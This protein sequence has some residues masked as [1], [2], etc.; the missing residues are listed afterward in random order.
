MEYVRI[1]NGVPQRFTDKDLKSFVGP[2]VSIRKLKDIPNGR[3]ADFN[4][5]P[6]VDPGPPSYDPVTQRVV[7]GDYVEQNGEWVVSYVVEDIP[8]SERE[9]EA[10]ATLQALVQDNE[11]LV[12]ITEA[13]V[14]AL[15]LTDARAR[16]NQPAVPKNALMQGIRQRALEIFRDRRG[17]E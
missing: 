7:R 1:V 13:L 12:A 6:V 10:Q 9:D 17:I 2:N 8:A 16:N 3:L 11:L 14:D 4:V 5:Y 15:I